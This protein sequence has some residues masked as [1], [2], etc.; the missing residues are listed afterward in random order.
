MSLHFESATKV[1][2]SSKQICT[3]MSIMEP[4][5]LYKFILRISKP[6]FSFRLQ[7]QIKILLNWLY[8]VSEVAY[9]A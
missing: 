2:K 7:C 6:L 1:W 9:Q 3:I 5:Q 4:D 8:P